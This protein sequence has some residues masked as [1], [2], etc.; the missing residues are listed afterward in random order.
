MP[1][2]LPNGGAVRR[3]TAGQ[4]VPITG[5][6]VSNATAE[7]FGRMGQ[8]VEGAA[9]DAITQQTAEQRRLEQLAED[10]NKARGLAATGEAKIRLHDT[11]RS[12]SDRILRGDVDGVAALG[13]WDNARTQITSDLTK[14]LPGHIA[15]RVG[16]QIKLDASE[17]AST[18]IGR[19]VE[20]RQREVTRADL[21]TSLEG[22]ERDA[23]TDRGKAM[24]LAGA[25]ISTL[26]ASAGYGPDDQQKLLQG[27]RETTAANM[28][29]QRLLASSRDPAKL[30][31]FEQQLRGED[32][33]D[34]SPHIRERFEVRIENK[35]AALQHA[36][37]VAQRRLE[38]A[39][40]RRLTE[41]EHAVRAVE[42]IVDGGG[43]ADDATLAKAQTAAMGT[44]WADVL[45]S[46][47][48]QAASRSAFGSLSP[49]QQDR[50]LLQ[51]RAKLNQTGANPHQMKQLQQLE[52]IRTRTREQV[53]R[54]PL[55]WGVQSRLLP[56]V[57]PLPMTSLPDL[58]QGLTQR[59]SQAATVSAQLQ[60]PVSPLLASE[61]QLLGESLGRLPADQKKTWLR[62]L[63]GVLPPDQ[64]RA[65][66]GQLKDQDGALAL[67]MH[68]GSLPKTAN[69]DPMDLIL[70]G[71]DAVASGRIKKDD[72]L[73]RG[74]RMK[75]S[76]E[77][78]AVPWA[79]PKARDAAIDAASIIMDGLRDQRSNGTASSSDRKKAM[80][81][82][83]GGEIVDHGDGKTVAPPG[84]TEH[85]FHAAMRK[86]TAED[87][88]RQAPGGLTL[89]GQALTP[90]A[91]VKALPS[92]R[93]VPLGPSRYALD[94][95]GIVLGTG[96]QPFAFTLGD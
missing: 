20:T 73:T 54:D 64:Q 40:A 68:A 42:S 95:G 59:T 62:G 14:E 51:L 83:L 65:L 50:A 27:F 11:M 87:I 93:L 31:A 28:A 75:L 49:M 52:S 4:A 12:L 71:H 21:N 2:F 15:E 81:L 53:D 91:L 58:V 24:T 34:L 86:V 78:D 90:D 63:A 35:R 26:G 46:T 70:R 76:R 22:F 7:A 56:E 9:L 57:A 37:E 23:L 66:A 55:A 74:E 19:A 80:L 45:K 77:L 92:A 79:T 8:V 84:W 44:P 41:A 72:E 94:L 18:G 30:D 69:G 43:I 60:R 48:Q 3:P 82:A 67:A 39:R 96:R 1:Q 32:F 85:R 13:E 25:A 38:A 61:A 29:E 88:A 47:V 17:L 89:N 5:P 10:A 36:A 6:G 16:A 33:N